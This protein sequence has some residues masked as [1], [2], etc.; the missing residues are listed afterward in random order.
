MACKLCR[1]LSKQIGGQREDEL[2]E[3]ADKYESWAVGILERYDGSAGV[4]AKAT[5]ADR[6][7]RGVA[8]ESVQASMMLTLVPTRT[9]PNKRRHRRNRNNARLSYP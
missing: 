1:R 4:K 7:G 9:L 3:L 8:T 5:K 6:S 2:L